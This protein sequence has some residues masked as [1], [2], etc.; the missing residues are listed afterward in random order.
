MTHFPIEGIAR[1]RTRMGLYGS[2]RHLRHASCAS[3]E[4]KDRGGMVLVVEGWRNG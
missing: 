3:G 2:V 4:G 1:A